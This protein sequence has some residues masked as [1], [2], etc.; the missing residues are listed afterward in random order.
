ML[1]VG[2]IGVLCQQMF[3]W[4]VLFTLLDDQ[5]EGQAACEKY[6]QTKGETIVQLIVCNV[7]RNKLLS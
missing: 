2:P 7:N 3:F 4:F 5:Q 1:N 6:G